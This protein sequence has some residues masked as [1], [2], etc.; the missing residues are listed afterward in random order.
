MLSTHLSGP[1]LSGPLLLRLRPILL[2]TLPA[3][4]AAAALLLA[5]IAPSAAQAQAQAQFGMPP[6]PQFGKPFGAPPPARPIVQEHAR[7]I[8]FDWRPVREQAARMAAA[9]RPDA[10][11]LIRVPI[12]DRGG[13]GQPMTAMT[14]EIP[15][16]WVP[17]GGVDWDQSVECPWN[18]PRMRWSAASPDGLFGVAILPELGWQVA[19]RPVDR[20]DPC[21]VAPMSSPRDYLQFLAR[22]TRPGAV[23]TGY[24]D[25]PELVSAANA[26]VQ[27]QPAGPLGR[28]LHQ[29]GELQISYRL[30]GH[31]MHESLV[32]ALTLTPLAG[33]AVAINTLITLGVRAPAGLHD[34]AFAEQIR[35]SLRLDETWA[36][37]RVQWSAGRWQQVRQRA[38]ATINAWHQRR[39]S[40]I[41]LAGMTARHQI[42]METIA[43]I[44]RIN[45]RIV[46][47]TSATNDRI[48][49]ET[50]RS[51]QEVQPWRDPSTGQQ[52]DL[53]IHYKYAWQLGDGRQ[54]LT[55]DPNFDPNRDLNMPGR[56][57]EQVR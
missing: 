46:A 56:R 14:V 25:R 29:A 28:V 44:G 40:E 34:A 45:N 33:G 42:R 18:A 8:F 51:I 30:Q 7:G 27:R 9:N 43:D 2:G 20:F 13:F 11:Q 31:E 57:L 41:N 6:S 47:N 52:V 23:V 35:K 1:F 24:R 3:A 15:S 48:H 54:F 38:A 4:A 32:S 53:S 5:A 17:Q 49:R 19:G 50:I 36:K 21:P 12:V 55:N 39:I 37:R 10:R 16:D 26:Q 22:S